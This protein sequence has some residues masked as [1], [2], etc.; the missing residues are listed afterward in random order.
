MPDLFNL[1][2]ITVVG[3]GDMLDVEVEAHA[4]G[5]GRDEEIDVAVLV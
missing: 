3:K 2:F 5:V 1:Q 4:D